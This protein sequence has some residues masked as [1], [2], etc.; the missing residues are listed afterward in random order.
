MVLIDMAPKRESRIRFAFSFQGGRMMRDGRGAGPAS[1]ASKMRIGRCR[2]MWSK[3][4]TSFILRKLKEVAA[5]PFSLVAYSMNLCFAQWTVL[6]L[7]KPC[8]KTGEVEMVVKAGERCGL[9]CDTVDADD[10]N[11]WTG[12]IDVLLWRFREFRCQCFGSS[13]C[14]PL[15]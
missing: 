5:S 11:F 10:A 4:Q 6:L 3:W 15:P 12:K 9:V 7:L 8:A 14:S 13:V 2:W 1:R